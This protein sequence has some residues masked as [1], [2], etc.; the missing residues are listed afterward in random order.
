MGFKK[1]YL[2]GVDHN[3]AINRNEDGT[4]KINKELL[5]KDHFD[6]NYYNSWFNDEKKPSTNTELMNKSYIAAKNYCDKNGI[7]IYN[8]TRG[9]KLEVFPRVNFDELF[10]ES[11]RFIEEVNVLQRK[12]LG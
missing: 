10:D 9:G 8:A 3:Y 2:I 12:V 11:G 5:G 4:Y 7:E 6:R 1:I